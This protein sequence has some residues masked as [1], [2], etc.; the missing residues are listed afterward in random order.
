MQLYLTLTYDNSEK[1][2]E[3]IINLSK[4]EERFVLLNSNKEI[5]KEE[6]YDLIAA[7][8][9]RNE[10]V[11]KKNNQY[12]IDLIRDYFNEDKDWI[13]GHINYDFKNSI[14][15]LESKNL[16]NIGFPQAYFF[17]PEM[18]FIA[19]N[20]TLNIFISGE[21]KSLEKANKFKNSLENTIDYQLI[22][23]Q[24]QGQI[25]IIEKRISKLDYQKNFNYIK[26][27][28]Q[29]GNIYEINYCQEF[30]SKKI[31]IDPFST[32]KNLNIISRAPMSAFY[33]WENNF[34]MSASPER[35]I[36]KTGEKVI[37]QPIK[38]TSRRFI[39]SDRDQESSEILKESVKERAENVMIVDLVRND[40]SKTAKIGS[41]KVEELFGIYSFPQVH[42]MISTITSEL[43]PELDIFDLIKTTFPMGSMTGAP[44]ISAMQIIDEVESVSRGL[45]SGTLGYITPEGNADFN[46]IIRSLQYNQETEYLSLIT[47]GA[48]TNMSEYE[49]EYEEC[50]LKAEAIFKALNASQEVGN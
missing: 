32:Y 7:L 48:I 47:G 45:Y 44:K 46:V 40:L 4:N 29:K 50:L 2:L 13:F 42:Q 6:E 3:T 30:Y 11:I 17:R 34:L 1:L 36:K 24:F 25:V 28:I 37:S 14:E 49:S 22:N 5:Y 21:N 41:V 31:K 35:Y 27:Q 20:H 23:P 26:D 19:K 39:D 43:K 38:G 8:G 33:K 16:D 10:I 9:V 15:N 12:N 18:L